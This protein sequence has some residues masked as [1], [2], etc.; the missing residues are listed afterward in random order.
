MDNILPMSFF[1]LSLSL[2]FFFLSFFVY[3][4]KK[5]KKKTIITKYKWKLFC[6]EH[7]WFFGGYN[8]YFSLQLIRTINN[9]LVDY[10]HNISVL[11]KNKMSKWQ[12]LK[13]YGSMRLSLFV[14]YEMADNHYQKNKVL[15]HLISHIFDNFSLTLKWI[16]R[17]G[18][19]PPYSSLCSI[20]TWF[21]KS[22][23]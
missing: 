2:E 5:K 4:L 22:L 1:S 16:S 19:S 20:L 13:S 3:I 10:R 7:L 18:I 21:F 6:W 12:R 11:I 8:Y 15:Y 14:C 9:V 23:K 17:V